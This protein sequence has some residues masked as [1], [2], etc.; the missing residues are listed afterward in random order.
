VIRGEPGVGKTALLRYAA[1]QASGFRVAQIRGVESEMELPYAGLHQLCAP[2]LALVD[3]VPE[4]QQAALSV[5]FGLSSGAAPDRFLIA[6]ATL[7][8][9]AQCGEER[10]LLCLVDDGQWLDSASGQ[11]LGFV[12]RRLL[13]ESVAIVFAVRDDSDVRPFAGLPQLRL[14]GLPRDDARGLLT[15]VVP[16]RLDDRVRDCI[17]A[18]TR[19]NP[20]ALLELPRGMSAAELAGGFALP[21]GDLPGQIE[22][23][24]VQRLRALPDD[25]QRLTLLAAAE[26]VGDA[27]L[28]WRASQ[29]LGIGREAAEPARREQLLE[30]GPRVQFRHPLVRSAVYRAAPAEDRRAAHNALAAATDAE[31]DPDR[32]AWHRAQATSG[33]PVHGRGATDADVT[34]GSGGIWERLHYDW[35]DPSRV[36]MTTTDSNVW[37]GNSGHTYTFTRRP[38]GTTDVDAVVVREGKNL[39]GRLLGAVLGSIGKGRLAKAFA[40]SVVAIE[41]RAESERQTSPR[42]ERGQTHD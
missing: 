12:G 28:V 38:D 23:L 33:L 11:V 25:T 35:S 7:S 8:L 6:L 26:P 27:A 3:G 32:Y 5:A 13:A 21:D 4:P 36:V 2:L 29:A 9:L 18:E 24:Y 39:R 41:A 20:L 16:G 14:E 34:E 17:V 15:T 22:D 1:R 30:I 37:G 42:N 31:S 40:T 10:P 19:G